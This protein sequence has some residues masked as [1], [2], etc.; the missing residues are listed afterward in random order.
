ME[1]IPNESKN[2]LAIFLGK[3]EFHTAAVSHFIDKKARGV[4]AQSL[5]KDLFQSVDNNACKGRRDKA[6][7]IPEFTVRAVFRQCL[8]SL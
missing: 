2:L 7:F 6:S 4:T 5:F 3:D 8:D 1:V